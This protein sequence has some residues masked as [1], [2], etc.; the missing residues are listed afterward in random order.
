VSWLP[1]CQALQTHARRDFFPALGASP[2]LEGVP[3]GLAHPQLVEQHPLRQAVLV[4]P[5]AR[6]DEVDIAATGQRDDRGLVRCGPVDLCPQCCGVRRVVALG[7]EG[8][9]DL[10][11]QPVV[12]EL[13]PVCVG[14]RVRDERPAGESILEDLR[15]GGE[16]GAEGDRVEGGLNAR[17]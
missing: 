9:V 4:V 5:H 12:T 7:G 10:C 16:Q 11:V 6:G 15:G 2:E 17:P 13:G 8:A 1:P 14:D 3:V